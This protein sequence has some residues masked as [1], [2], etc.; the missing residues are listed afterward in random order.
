MVLQKRQLRV[1]TSPP[2][3]IV[4]V[5][6]AQH[7]WRLGQSPLVQMVLSLCRSIMPAVSPVLPLVRRS[8]FSQSG[9]I[10]WAGRPKSRRSIL[11]AVSPLTTAPTSVPARASATPSRVNGRRSIGAISWLSMSPDM[12][13]SPTKLMS[14]MAL[15]FTSM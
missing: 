6:A 3:M 5:R 14:A 4:A 12:K 1:H 13:K 2:I 9:F 10:T 11:S 7:S 8:I 15:F